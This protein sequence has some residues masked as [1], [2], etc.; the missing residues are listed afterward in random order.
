LT[1]TLVPA[2]RL[3]I[4]NTYRLTVDGAAQSGVRGATELLLDGKGDGN[5]GSDYEAPITWRTLA[6]P[7]PGFAARAL[8]KK[9]KHT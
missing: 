9:A 7:A 5:P 4:H 3:D 6:G 8:A 2:H 1:V